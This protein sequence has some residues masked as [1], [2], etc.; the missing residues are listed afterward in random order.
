MATWHFG[1]AI[2]LPTATPSAYRVAAVKHLLTFPVTS[3]NPQH[4]AHQLCIDA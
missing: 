1:V 3:P 4:G 2:M